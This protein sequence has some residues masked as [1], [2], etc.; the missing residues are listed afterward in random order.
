MANQRAKGQKLLTVPASESFIRAIDENLA[1]VGYNNRSQFIRDAIL[2]KFE[3][4]KI[5]LPSIAARPVQ[6]A[7][8]ARFNT[9]APVVKEVPSFPPKPSMSEVVADADR[10]SYKMESA[11]NNPRRKTLLKRSGQTAAV[12]PP[13]TPPPGP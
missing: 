1:A 6:R 9:A 8:M 5:Y 12:P 7:G 3:A 2:E 13:S 10:K 11:R 4:K